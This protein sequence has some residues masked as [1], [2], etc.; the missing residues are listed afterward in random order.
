MM[1]FL[2]AY[3]IVGVIIVWSLIEFLEDFIGESLDPRIPER[4]SGA[5]LLTILAWPLVVLYAHLT[6]DE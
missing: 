6:D 1:L 5:I 4:M 2:C 3:L